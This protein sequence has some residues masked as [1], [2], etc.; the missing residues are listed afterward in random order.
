L[1]NSY[2]LLY[3]LTFNNIKYGETKILPEY[4]DT[5]SIIEYYINKI[6]SKYENKNIKSIINNKLHTSVKPY[7]QN[8]FNLLK[9]ITNI[10]QQ[11]ENINTSFLHLKLQDSNGIKKYSYGYISTNLNKLLFELNELINVIDN[12]SLHLFS[13][14]VDI[15]F[16]RRFL[17]KNY[18]TTAITYTGS[19]H[20]II[21]ITTLIQEFDFKI[22]HY[23][24]SKINNINDLNKKIKDAKENYEIEELLYPS[25][26]SQCSNLKDFPPKFT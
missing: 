9:N 20:S 25:I 11:I 3:K 6:L 22:T 15:F 7:F 5:Y 16:L 23:S 2:N 26:L 8:I 18:I 24:Y 14:Y 13:R 19:A 10:I 4:K 17:D 1:Y 12:D 21:Y